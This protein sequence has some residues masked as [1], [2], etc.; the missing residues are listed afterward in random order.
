MIGEGIAMSEQ[1]EK[2]RQRVEELVTQF[3]AE[4][5]RREWIT[6]RYPKRLRDDARQVYEIPALYL[7]KGPTSLLLDPIGYDVPGPRRLPTF[8]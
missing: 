8:T 7:Q 6:R 4:V 3:E 2:S 1:R 5:D